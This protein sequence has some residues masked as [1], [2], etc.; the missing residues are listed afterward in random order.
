MVFNQ[1]ILPSASS[2]NYEPLLTAIVLSMLMLFIFV[3][4]YDFFGRSESVQTFF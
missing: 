1:Q 3:I 4:L 2:V